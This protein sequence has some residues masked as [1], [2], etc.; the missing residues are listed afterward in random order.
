MHT[1][2]LMVLYKMEQIDFLLDDKLLNSRC[3]L[4]KL[5]CKTSIVPYTT[6]VYTMQILLNPNTANLGNLHFNQGYCLKV[7]N[8]S[9]GSRKYILGVLRGFIKITPGKEI[10]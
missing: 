8:I 9:A 6:G 2:M 5:F 7:A 4:L 3:V 1:C 10:T